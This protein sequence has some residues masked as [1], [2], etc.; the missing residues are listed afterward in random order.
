MLFGSEFTS[1]KHGANTTE[2]HAPRKR[3]GLPLPRPMKMAPT[4][5][6][7]SFAQRLGDLSKMKKAHALKSLRHACFAQA[8]NGGI[9]ELQHDFGVS[10][11]TQTATT[12]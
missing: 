11:L 6:T 2:D 3:N 5:R 7:L 8:T 12:H 4:A 1:V 9:A 10:C